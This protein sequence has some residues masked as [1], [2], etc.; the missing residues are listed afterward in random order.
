[1]ELDGVINEEP[2]FIDRALRGTISKLYARHIMR[3]SRM[4]VVSVLVWVEEWLEEVEAPTDEKMSNC[5]VLNR[6][7]H[8][9]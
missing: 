3:S 7:Q 4:R 9:R 8:N 6:T 2:P 1:M 5:Q